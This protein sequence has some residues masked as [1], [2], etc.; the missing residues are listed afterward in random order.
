[1]TWA[2][3]LVVACRSTPPPTS[4][5]PSESPQST[6]TGAVDTQRPTEAGSTAD[7]A[8]PATPLADRTC[9]PVPEAVNHA[10]RVYVNVDELVG[11]WDWFDV[12]ASFFINE[13]HEEN[14]DIE[15]V[16]SDDPTDD[17]QWVE[18]VYDPD[19]H[20]EK[21]SGGHVT[22]SLAGQ[23]YLLKPYGNNHDYDAPEVGLITEDVMASFHGATI[24][25][26]STGS[27][28][29]PAFS[30]PDIELYPPHR[31][32]LSAPLPNEVL[33]PDDI[34]YRW[35]PG[36][37]LDGR[38]EV[39][40]APK[41]PKQLVCMIDDDGEWSPP[42]A[43]FEHM[44]EPERLAARFRARQWCPQELPDG[45]IVTIWLNYESG[46]GVDVVPY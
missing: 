45:R 41:I 43:V 46:L 15:P 29:V 40:L 18:N 5:P 1:M 11:L 30:F 20:G 9:L 26:E 33:S 42:P 25:I 22:V 31:I 32:D 21:V 23:S 6:A 19:S 44:N 8:A 34:V 2:L 36:T 7:S 12:S 16:P 3:L 28:D 39:R 13:P 14:P 27:P 38:M 10:G 24:S 37:T 35:E 4:S 17:C